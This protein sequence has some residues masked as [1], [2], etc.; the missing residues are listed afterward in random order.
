[1]TDLVYTCVCVCRV[2]LLLLVTLLII[3]SVFNTY[4]NLNAFSLTHSDDCS[5]EFNNS[6]D[7]LAVIPNKGL[8]LF[9]LN[10]QAITNNLDM[11]ELMVLSSSK[12]RQKNNII[13]LFL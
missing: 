10:I 5:F 6:S 1:M 12:S 13:F 11:V 8:T 7:P 2:L 3:L 4:Y 9:Y